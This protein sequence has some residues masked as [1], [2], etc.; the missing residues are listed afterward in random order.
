MLAYEGMQNNCFYAHPEIIDR[1]NHCQEMIVLYEFM[2]RK[3]GLA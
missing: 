1:E 2:K 3:E